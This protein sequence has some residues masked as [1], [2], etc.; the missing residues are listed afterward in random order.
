MT[1][2]ASGGVFAANYNTGEVLG[3]IGEH[4]DSV[5]SIVIS[6]EL[7]FAA[8]AGIDCNILVY[9]LKDSKIRHRIEP[10]Q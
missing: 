8:S 4:K 7:Q 3:K 10:T 2:G 6:Q 9:D 1:G 5:E